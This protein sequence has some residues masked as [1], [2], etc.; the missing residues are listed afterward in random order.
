MEEEVETGE[1]EEPPAV[2]AA[3]TVLVF[4]DYDGE[5]LP[6][7][8]TMDQLSLSWRK[9]VYIVGWIQVHLV[10]LHL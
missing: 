6:N 1:P 5:P 3:G 7:N 2:P 4:S 8:Y 10:K 9:K